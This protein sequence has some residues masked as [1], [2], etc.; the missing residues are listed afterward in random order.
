LVKNKVMVDA[1]EEAV[2]VVLEITEDEG[3]DDLVSAGM[4]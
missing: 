4:V 1:K 3:E 2:D